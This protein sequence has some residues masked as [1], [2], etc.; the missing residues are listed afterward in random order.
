MVKKR[1]WDKRRIGYY[2]QSIRKK[3]Q[4]MK[5]SMPFVDFGDIA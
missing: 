1:R 5:E 3:Y 4:N 2:E